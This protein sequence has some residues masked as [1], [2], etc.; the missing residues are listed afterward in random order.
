MAEGFPG[1]SA[2]QNLPA[3]AET[4]VGSLVQE[5]PAA[6]ALQDRALQDRAL[7]DR[8]LQDRALQDRALQDRALQSLRPATSAGPPEPGPRGRMP[9]RSSSEKPAQRQAAQPETN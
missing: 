4:Q 8:A 7:Q 6:P 5:G 9:A 3:D 1:G 2:V